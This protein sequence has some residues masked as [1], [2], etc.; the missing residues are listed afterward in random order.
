MLN[1][2]RPGF[3]FGEYFNL[4]TINVDNEKRIVVFSASAVEPTNA[5]PRT[6]LL[7]LTKGDYKK[8]IG[9]ESI[10]LMR[11]I[12]PV[13]LY[14]DSGYFSDIFAP[15]KPYDVPKDVLLRLQLTVDLG[16]SF[17]VAEIDL[18]DED[19]NNLINKIYTGEH[20]WTGQ[21]SHQPNVTVHE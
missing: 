2:H 7:A 14:P 1:V 20:F 8:G 17:G 5:K 11:S 9:S 13:V 12:P 15:K 19:Y 10:F 3:P 4:N 18:R 6:P 21:F 16:F